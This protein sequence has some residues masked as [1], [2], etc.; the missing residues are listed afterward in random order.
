MRAHLVRSLVAV[1][2]IAAMTG[3]VALLRPIA[4]DISLGALYTLV[5]L[6]AAIAFGMPYAIGVSVV[7][8]LAFNF[9][10]LP[11]VHTLSLANARD[12]TAL[13]VYLVTGVVASQ[14]ASTARRRARD[15]EAREQGAVLLADLAARLLEGADPNDLL[16][17]VDHNDYRLVAAVESLS[18]MARE[19][20]RLRREAVE[21]EALRRSD[22]VK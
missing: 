22:E 7:S 1:A 14:L 19:R 17:R 16:A 4:P 20:E 18:A 13:V 3:I 10:V 21:A 8:L 9:F 11:P 2:A 6:G 15:A 12:W 5:V